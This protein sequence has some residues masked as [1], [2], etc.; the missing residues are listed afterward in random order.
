MN[1]LK[2]FRRVSGVDVE[3]FFNSYNDFILG[4]L[5]VIISYLMG[6]SKVIPRSEQVRFGNLMQSLKIIDSAIEKV[7]EDLSGSYHWE[8]LEE[9]TNAGIVLE[10]INKLPKF[11]RCSFVNN[12]YSSN[13]ALKY[14]QKQGETLEKI[15][16]KKGSNQPDNSFYQTTIRNRVIEEDYTLEGGLSL[17]LDFDPSVSN[18]NIESTVSI[19]ND[20]ESLLGI[21]L[22]RN[23]T[24]DSVNEDLSV[25]DTSET[26]LQTADILLGL[27]KEDNP[28][29]PGQGIDTA[30]VIGSNLASFAYPTLVRQVSESYRTDDTFKSISLKNI[31]FE[32]DSINFTF[33]ITLIDGT[34]SERSL[35][36]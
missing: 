15:E 20:S 11:L 10:K 30:I 33:D 23:I 8:L 18:F 22:N 27:K 35:I 2:T 32:Q 17:E 19:I 14:T 31:N 3:L 13:P 6:D 7:K 34:K 26:V 36:I 25:L 9:L 1:N 24:F 16:R 4:D 5:P 29:F 12:D 21:D 28:E